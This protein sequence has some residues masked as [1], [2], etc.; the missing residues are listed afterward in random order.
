MS[1]EF[2]SVHYSRLQVAY[3]GIGASRS[4][5]VVVNCCHDSLR[6]IYLP[7][8]LKVAS[9]LPPIV[10]PHLHPI[11]TC[12]GLFYSC[13]CVLKSNT[14]SLAIMG[15]H[16]PIFESINNPSRSILGEFL[17]LRKSTFSIYEVPCYLCKGRS[18]LLNNGQTTTIENP[19]TN[20]STAHPQD[21]VIGNQ[22]LAIIFI[23]FL[24]KLIC[25]NR[26][27]QQ[28]TSHKR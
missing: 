7:S 23:L 16:Y 22:V 28:L 15:H 24:L 4:S 11:S 10:L 2:N 5:C 25:L 8:A 13:C 17:C 3:I 9:I 6:P 26:L 21:E 18:S 20:T 19:I 12:Y 14:I 27:I 1:L